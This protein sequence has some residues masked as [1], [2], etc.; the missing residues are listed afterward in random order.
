MMEGRHLRNI[1]LVVLDTLRALALS[2]QVSEI[3]THMRDS[4]FD[5]NEYTEPTTLDSGTNG[6]FFQVTKYD[7]ET[8]GEYSAFIERPEGDKLSSIMKHVILTC[9]AN[10]NAIFT[11]TPSQPSYVPSH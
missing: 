2:H 4:E 3:Q 10:I 11:G 1:E 7:P 6:P 5:E 9:E 8:H